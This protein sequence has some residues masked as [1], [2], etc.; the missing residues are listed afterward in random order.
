MQDVQF[1]KGSIL[2]QTVVVNH[3]SY[4]F[5]NLHSSFQ[6]VAPHENTIQDTEGLEFKTL[7]VL[8]S[9]FYQ[10][11]FYYSAQASAASLTALHVC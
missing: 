6:F 9:E 4:I 3:L 8:N 11:I 10:L 5:L 2:F 1:H 7:K